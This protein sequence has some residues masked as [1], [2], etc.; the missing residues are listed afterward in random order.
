MSAFQ[1][2]W[3]L[4]LISLLLIPVVITKKD[5]PVT[6]VAWLLTIVFLPV[7]GAVIFLIFG[8]DRITNRG[9]KKLTS[10]AIL[11]IR[12]REIEEEWAPNKA[13]MA[14]NEM[15]KELETI[16][17]LCQQLSLF[18]VVGYN[19]VDILVDAEDTYLKI[20]EAIEAATEHINV[21]Y[22]I[23]RPDKTGRRFR[24][25]LANKAKQGV[26]INFLYDAIGSYKLGWDRTFLQGFWEAGIEP[27]EFLPLRTFFRPWNMNLRNHRKILVIDNQIGFTGSLNIG[28]DFLAK[29][30]PKGVN[31]RETHLMIRGPAAA[32]LQWVFCE[33]WYFA[34]D[35][36][37]LSP[38]YFKPV[39]ACGKEIVQVVAS[40][41]DE[42][43]EV[44]HKAVIMAVNQARNSVYIT[45]PYFIPDQALS[46]SLEMAAMRGV[47]VR[48]LV[49]ARSDHTLVS[50]AG[51]SYY[52]NL[53]R[54]YVR[55]YEYKR[56][57]LHA[58]MMIVDGKFTVIGSANV[59]IRS[60]SYNFEVNVQIY[61]DSIANRAKKIFFRDL[62]NS[63]ELVAESYLNRP[64]YI[65]F[66]ENFCRLFSPVL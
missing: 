26:K 47:D 54:N 10:N 50:Y 31:W 53:L 30:Q 22:Y 6:S 66:S 33:D 29:N 34:T 56:G 28:D 52:D 43:E 62:E 8:T 23:F 16:R 1:S 64:A 48:L 39:D 35:E 58:K 45:S 3:L 9:R 38:Q 36:E 2:L 65:R 7:V 44:I 46:L 17:K 13:Q 21:E 49:P 12:L 51:R 40:G 25:L 41:P 57:Y 20:E 42:S 59:D 60:F 14:R 55:I 18:D 4:Y 27:K 61:G 15:P 63:R 24:D 32:Q 11:R 37:L 19:Q 5:K